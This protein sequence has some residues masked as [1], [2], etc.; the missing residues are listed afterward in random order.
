MLLAAGGGGGNRH[1]NVESGGY[2]APVRPDS[3]VSLSPSAVTSKVSGFTPEPRIAQRSKP[4]GIWFPSWRSSQLSRSFARARFPF[5]AACFASTLSR[6][7]QR[8]CTIGST[9]S[10][11][12]TSSLKI[13]CF[14]YKRSAPSALWQLRLKNSNASAQESFAKEDPGPT[15]FAELSKE[16]LPHFRNWQTAC[17][18]SFADRVFEICFRNAEFSFRG[19]YLGNRLD[20][21]HPGVLGGP[22]RVVLIVSDFKLILCSLN[23]IAG[24]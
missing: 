1:T 8:V 5:A 18:H 12:D 3:Q 17:A 22:F 16:S 6:R 21:D 20:K 15:P 7:G 23:S 10:T 4:I 14:Q 13:V 2:V 19:S 9:L 11:L 24:A